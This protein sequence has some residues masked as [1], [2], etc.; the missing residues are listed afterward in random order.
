[1]RLT[2]RGL[3]EMQGE[4]KLFQAAVQGDASRKAVRAGAEVIR[5]AM[6]E[7]TPVL[8]KKTAESTALDPG[9]LKG[10]MGVKFDRV[11]KL[12]FLRAWIGPKK[13]G[14]VAYWVEFGHFLVKGG[15]L[16]M[17]RGKLRGQGHRVGEVNAHPFLRPGYEASESSA[18]S[19]Y[20]AE[21]KKQLGK[22]VR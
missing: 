4:L 10:D 21:L 14:H 18:F 6:E 3:D 5:D 8:D 16:S 1:M 7:R 9:S 19:A 2:T 17:K 13:Y 20:V 12:G 11:D 15:Y 22:W